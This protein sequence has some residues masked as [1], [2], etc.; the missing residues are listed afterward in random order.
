[1]LSKEGRREAGSNLE[2]G[3][4]RNWCISPC[5]CPI[6]SSTAS[7]RR[8][9][10]DISFSSDLTVVVSFLD[11]RLFALV[12]RRIS[13]SFSSVVKLVNGCSSEEEP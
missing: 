5:N 12:S 1:M 13:N 11:S 2:S 10:L 9:E 4:T 3:L 8:D 7:K 6:W